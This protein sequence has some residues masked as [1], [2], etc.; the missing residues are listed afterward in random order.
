MFVCTV[1][2]ERW[3]S[4]NWRCCTKYSCVHC[5]EN[6]KR[7]LRKEDVGRSSSFSITFT[8]WF[9]Q[10]SVLVYFFSIYSISGFQDFL[11]HFLFLTDRGMCVFL[12]VIR[13]LCPNGCAI[14]LCLLFHLPSGESTSMFLSTLGSGMSH[15]ECSGGGGWCFTALSLS[16]T[17][18]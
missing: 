10:N 16:F 7:C 13:L 15:E 8:I 18:Q 1:S 6:V 14:T 3:L 4:G 5:T 9:I 17:L 11:W 2:S 12:Q